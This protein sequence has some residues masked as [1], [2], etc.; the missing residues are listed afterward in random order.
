[1]SNVRPLHCSMN[2]RKLH[3][4]PPAAAHTISITVATPWHKHAIRLALSWTD[5]WRCVWLG[6]ESARNAG[7]QNLTAWQAKWVK[8]GRNLKGSTDKLSNGIPLLDAVSVKQLISDLSPSSHASALRFYQIEHFSYYSMSSMSI[9]WS[10][11]YFFLQCIISSIY[12][13]LYFFKAF[14]VYLPFQCFRCKIFIRSKIF[15]NM[16]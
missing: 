3:S 10:V 9:N 4:S 2:F 12:L 8:I 1:M 15:T 14:L 5:P 16:I 13:I 6:W 11:Q 7:Q